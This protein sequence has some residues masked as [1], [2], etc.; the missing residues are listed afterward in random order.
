M[1]L[2]N[3]RYDGDEILRKKAKVVKD[4]TKNVETLIDDLKDTMIHYN[5][6]GIA[7]SQV[8]ILKRVVIIEYEGTYYEMINPE[9]ISTE[10][11]QCGD[12]GCLSIPG[13]IGTV[14]RPEKLTVRYL[15][16]SGDDKS[17]EAGERLAVIISHEVDHLNGILY[18]DKAAPDTFRE[19][20]SEEDEDAL[21]EDADF[22]GEADTVADSSLH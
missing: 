3:L 8:G 5:G 20:T 10:G 16:R 4:I 14:E 11:S 2:R 6:V 15:D 18:K 12:E 17:L 19:N 1:A 22:E 13:M 21:E 9:I 7:A